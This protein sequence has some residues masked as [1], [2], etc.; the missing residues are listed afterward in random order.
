MIYMLEPRYC[1][2]QHYMY[3]TTNLSRQP[4][5]YSNPVGIAINNV[6]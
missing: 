1:S 5:N 4:Y 2:N 3:M 6:T